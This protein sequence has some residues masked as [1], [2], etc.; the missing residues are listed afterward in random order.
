MLTHREHLTNARLEGF[1]EN[2]ASQFQV[3]NS[4]TS[5]RTV[6]LKRTWHRLVQGARPQSKLSPEG[7]ARIKRDKLMREMV[8]PPRGELG[9]LGLNV[10]MKPS[11]FVLGGVHSFVEHSREPRWNLSTS[12][13]RWEPMLWE[14]HIFAKPQETLR[15]VPLCPQSDCSTMLFRKVLNSYLRLLIPHDLKPCT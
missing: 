13:L 12:S 1:S 11:S 10:P 5:T 6:V 9:Q 7:Q 2:R 8:F 14:L 3:G 15:K 4:K